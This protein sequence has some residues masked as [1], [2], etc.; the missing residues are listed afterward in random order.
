MFCQIFCNFLLTSCHEEVVEVEE[1]EVGAEWAVVVE[2]A[3]DHSP[4]GEK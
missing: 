1:V 3:E 4:L 2:E